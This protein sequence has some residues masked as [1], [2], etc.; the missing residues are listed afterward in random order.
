M[1]ESLAVSSRLITRCAHTL[2]RSQRCTF[3]SSSVS[4]AIYEKDDKGGFRKDGDL[5]F[6]SRT[7]MIRDGFKQLKTEIMLWKDEVKEKLSMDP[8][9]FA[10]KGEVDCLWDFKDP[11]TLKKFQLASDKDHNHGYSTCELKMSPA[12]KGLFT[13][14]IDATVPKDGIVQSSGYC[15]MRSYRARKSFKRDS[16]LNWSM[17]NTLVIRVRGD[18]RSYQLN[19]GNAGYYDLMWNDVFTFVLYTRGGPYWQLTK[20]PFSKFFFTSK[21]RIQDKQRPIN[22]EMVSHFGITATDTANGDF[23]LEID[24]IGLEFDPEHTEEFAY[25]TYKHDNYI[26]GN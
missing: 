3:H 9:A 24:Y 15:S 4:R 14:Y 13:G 17:Y 20:I 26:V 19:I 8:L 11:E 22:L 6:P 21:G 1:F 12:G 2:L 23:S 16:Y 25:E 5:K 10:R 18:G 7:E